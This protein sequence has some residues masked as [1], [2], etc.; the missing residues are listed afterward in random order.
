MNNQ[1]V[2]QL[3]KISHAYK[4]GDEN[5]QILHNADFTLNHGEI[6]ALIAPSGTGKSTLLHIAGLLEKPQKGEIIIQGRK[7][8]RLNDRE[9]TQLRLNSIGFVYQFHHL[10]A[11]FTALENVLIPQLIARSSKT[12][13]VN[14]GRDWLKKFGLGHRVDHYPGKLS[15]GEKQRV[16]IARALVNSPKILLADEPTGNL[17]EK[18]SEHVFNLLLQVVRSEGL[19]ALIVTHNYCLA[20]KMDRI[21]TLHEGKIIPCHL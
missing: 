8:S 18:N 14:I 2:L 19:T 17:D 15:G 12:K 20:T 7:S 5:L 6:V 3:D 11:E 13:A 21:V 16:A 4:N 1:V 9:R 10:L